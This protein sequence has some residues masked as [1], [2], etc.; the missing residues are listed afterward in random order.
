MPLAKSLGKVL[1]K[2]AKQ[3]SQ[4]HVKG[5]K[6]KQLNR[7]TER[8][9]HLKAKKQRFAEQKNHELLGF[10]H[11]QELANADPKEVYTIQDLQNYVAEY[12]KRFDDEIAEAE[13]L[14]RPGRALTT[15]QQLLLE[16]RK[17]EKHIFQTGYRVPDITDAQTAE[18]VRAWNGTSGACSAW[19]FT[20]ITSEPQEQI[21]ED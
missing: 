2:I 16:K 20:L 12:L 18:R 14:R 8:E 21:M 7:A 4:L 13:L 9:N 19:K 1:K 5:R 11:I 15:K 3:S 6:F 10:L 17:H